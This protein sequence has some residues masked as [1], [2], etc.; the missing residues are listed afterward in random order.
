[1]SSK[2]EFLF[3]HSIYLSRMTDIDKIRRKWKWLRKKIKRYKQLE[4]K[5]EATEWYNIDYT[6]DGITLTDVQSNLDYYSDRWT[7]GRIYQMD[8]LV[9]HMK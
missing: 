3:R 7:R 1:M 8:I 5:S 6:E 2:S 9:R 4:T